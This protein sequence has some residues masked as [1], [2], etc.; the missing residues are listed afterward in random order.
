MS[1]H[2][3]LQGLD[4]NMLGQCLLD[5]AIAFSFCRLSLFGFLLCKIIY[6]ALMIRER[7]FS[8]KQDR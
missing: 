1:F 3:W 6:D 7:C 5:E 4:L 2:G 8:W